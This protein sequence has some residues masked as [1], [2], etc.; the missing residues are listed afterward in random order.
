MLRVNF[1]D[2][3]TALKK[4]LE[5]PVKA[6]MLRVNFSDLGTALKRSVCTFG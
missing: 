6:I 5:F 1:S 3:G 4:K 2:L